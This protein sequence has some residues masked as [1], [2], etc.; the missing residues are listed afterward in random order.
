MIRFPCRPAS[1]AAVVLTLSLLAAAP[2][3]AGGPVK[4]RAGQWET[5]VENPMTGKMKS[6]YCVDERFD[7]S[8]TVPQQTS[9]A[10]KMKNLRQ[11]AK[12]ISFDVDCAMGEEAGGVTTSSSMLIT[13]DFESNYSFSMTS[14]MK[15]PGMPA[16]MGPQKM[17]MKGTARWTGPCPKK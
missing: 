9:Q 15:I 6:S 17:S 4:P 1:L 2:A 12:S 16:G 14:S 3:L 11:S 5:E 8:R 13:G 10:C 7:W